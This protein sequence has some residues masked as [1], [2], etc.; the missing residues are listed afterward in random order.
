MFAPSYIN[1]LSDVAHKTWIETCYYPQFFAWHKLKV[2]SSLSYTLFA[3]KLTLPVSNKYIYLQ[4]D[5]G[6]TFS[7]NLHGDDADCL[8][9]R[10]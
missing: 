6:D 7:N 4:I 9:C 10:R 5:Y 1:T 3:V 2:S 8:C